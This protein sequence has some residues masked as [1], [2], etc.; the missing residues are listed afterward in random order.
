MDASSAA[1]LERPLL[2]VI[3]LNILVDATNE[4]R[5]TN[6]VEGPSISAPFL[7]TVSVEC[8]LAESM[9]ASATRTTDT[10]FFFIITSPLVILDL[11]LIDTLATFH[12]W[13]DPVR[14][15]ELLVSE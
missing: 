11:W 12:S 7:H 10:I 9:L 4:F 6:L 1:F 3:T 2:P 5:L 14:A 13:S 15:I 8:G